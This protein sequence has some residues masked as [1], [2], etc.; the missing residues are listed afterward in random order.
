MARPSPCRSS[1][2]A[3]S[4]AGYPAGLH[5]RLRAEWLGLTLALALLAAGL[6]IWRDVP[7]IRD[8]N[9]LGY[10]LGM[11]ATAHPAASGDVA[12]I[13]IDDA[14]IEALGYWPWRRSIHAALLERLGQARAV[15][16]DLILPDPHPTRPEDDAVLARAI[17]RHG[18]VVLPEVLDPSGD[19]RITPLPGLAEAAAAIGRI[20]AQPDPDGTLR[21]IE[22]RRSPSQGAPLPHFALALAR[23][24]GDGDALQ[25]AEAIPPDTASYIQFTDPG[26]RYALYPYAAVLDGRVPPETFRDRIVLI[27]AWASGLGDRLPT[28]MGGGLMAGVEILANIFQSL[29]DSSWIRMPPPLVLALAALLPVLPVCLGLRFLSPRWGLAGA[30]AAL[31]AFLAIDALLM[32]WARYWLPPAGPLIALLLAYPLWSWRCQEAS[33]RHID[34]ELERLRIPPR[35]EPQAGGHSRGPDTLPQRA[36]RLHHAISRLEQAA[37]AQEETLGF[38]SHDMRSPQSTILAAIEL[39]RRTPQQWS[40]ADTLA[41]IERQANATLGLVDQFVQLARAKSAALNL[42][43]CDLRDLLRDC[44]DRRCAQAMRRA[45]ELR[46]EEGDEEAVVP[47]DSDLMARAIGNLLDNAILY[48]A[49]GGTVDCALEREAGTWRIHIRDTGP[50][51]DPE[52]IGHLFTPFWRAPATAGRPGSGLG[53]AFVQTVAVRHGGHAACESRPGEGSRFTISLPARG[54]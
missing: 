38:I 25:S 14:S 16:L 48:S 54:A 13:A 21:W 6:S 40:E 47:V 30:L 3:V 20:D 52:Q 53:L 11:Q 43:P 5:R 27:G 28:A 7:G 33:L 15:G 36:V 50:G 46:C 8:I 24:A 45:I 41:H 44:C 2:P 37:K 9:R 35:G 18:R 26:R 22:L 34:A 49:E 17:A 10:D 23:V 51:I 1:E 19:H 42:R 4:S 12:I 29:R 32:Q 39:R 31:A